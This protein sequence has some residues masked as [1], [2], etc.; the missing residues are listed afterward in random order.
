MIFNQIITRYHTM[1]KINLKEEE[2][3]L[4]LELKEKSK[5]D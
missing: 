2:E 4:R 1:I 3:N 5:N